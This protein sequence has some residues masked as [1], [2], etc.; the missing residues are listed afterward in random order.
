MGS[1]KTDRRRSPRR[2][3]SGVY[4]LVESGH[5]SDEGPW[6]LSVLDINETGLAV[7]MP[8]EFEPGERVLAT[9]RL[10]K[11]TLLARTPV[12]VVWQHDDFKTGALEFGQLMAEER[13]AL[14]EFLREID[15]KA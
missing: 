10:G 11:R 14:A 6:E 2:P 15:S 1:D 8:A 3:L 12:K 9:L 7:A 5:G 13:R 4:V